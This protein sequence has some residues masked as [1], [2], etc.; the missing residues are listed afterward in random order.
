MARIIRQHNTLSGQNAEI[1][2]KAGGTYGYHCI[3]N[4]KYHK[5]DIRPTIFY[6]LLAE[7][8][9]WSLFPIFR[10]NKSRLMRSPRCLCVCVS[11]INFWMPEP[12]FMK[13][14]MNGMASE[15]VSLRVSIPLSLPSNSSVDTFPRQWIH[16]TI[17][18]LFDASF[19]MRFVSY[20]GKV[21]GSWA[22]WD[23]EPR[24]TLLARA[25]TNLLAWT[26]VCI[27]LSFLGNSSVKTF[28]R[29]RRIFGS[30][31]FYAVSVASKESRRLVLPGTSCLRWRPETRDVRI[32]YSL[33]WYPP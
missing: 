32:L 4:V 5:D 3:L 24:I 31:V 23:S 25:N 17:E 14:G 7:E 22:P 28:P 33:Q 2:V 26:R 18:E 19:S 10:K 21:C 13:L 16:A 29:Q 11:P 15:P 20:Q 6:H 1:Y 27:S 12:I 30:V 9:I 8:C